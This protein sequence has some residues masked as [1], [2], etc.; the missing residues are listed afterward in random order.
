MKYNL[1]NRLKRINY[2]KLFYRVLAVASVLLLAS[3]YLSYTRLYL[4]P[5]RRFWMAINNSLSTP[6]VV[7]ATETG[8]TGNKTTEATRF[9]Y[10]A[11]AAQNKL[12]SV[13]FKT[14]TS[15]SNV[16]TETI[17]TPKT[18]Y[19]RYVNIF[20]TEK[21]EGGG[22]YNFESVIGRWAK[23]D[24]GNEASALDNQR[25]TYIQPLVTLVP[26]GNL[27]ADARNELLAYMKSNGAY[28]V[29]FTNVQY[30]MENG[31][32]YAT[33]PVKVMTKKYVTALQKFFTAA[34]FG[35]FPPLDASGYPENA[36]VNA[37]FRIDMKSGTVAGISFNGQT[38]NYL[39]NGV[40][41]ELKMPTA[42]LSLD[43][44]QSRLQSAQ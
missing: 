38:E 18:Q 21:K 37:T 10:G 33:Y 15:E 13:S 26:F 30:Q 42:T 9:I 40:A 44:L 39:N 17:T 1:Q 12:N 19:V 31:K 4:T 20:S 6:S 43:E 32:K 22:A 28:N 27:T 29:D 35:D 36:R 25:L 16:T 3:A 2:Q 5:E 11:Q 7:K 23:Q 8:G 24:V 14:A 34:G 41:N